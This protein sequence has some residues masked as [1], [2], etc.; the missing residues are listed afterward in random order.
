MIDYAKVRVG[1]LL[2]VDTG[3]LVHVLEVFPNGVKV[4]SSSGEVG[5]FSYSSG[6]ARLTGFDCPRPLAPTTE[7][8][9]SKLEN[10]LAAALD[11]CDGVELVPFIPGEDLPGTRRPDAISAGPHKHTNNCACAG[12]LKW[13]DRHASVSLSIDLQAEDLH[14]EVQG[15]I[16]D[17]RSYLKVLGRQ[18]EQSAPLPL[19]VFTPMVGVIP[20]KLD[21]FHVR[22]ILGYSHL[23]QAM[24]LTFDCLLPEREQFGK[25]DREWLEQQLGKLKPSGGNH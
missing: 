24:L 14:K 19:G 4:E 6:A 5:N 15:R 11:R 1:D 22:A 8:V 13:T 12:A 25:A 10:L 2:V 7:P 23:H 9:P 3:A 16:A 17:W 20:F 21:G 18:P